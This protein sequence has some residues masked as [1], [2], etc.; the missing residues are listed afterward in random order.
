M[1]AEYR[2]D[3]ITSQL[4]VIY[5]FLNRWSNDTKHKWLLDV[6]LAYCCKTIGD[7]MDKDDD[8]KKKFLSYEHR[9][10]FK[11][12]FKRVGCHLSY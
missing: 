5:V 12:L 2:T 3:T 8:F 1:C 7:E 10:L 9:L 11:K 4:D 6:L